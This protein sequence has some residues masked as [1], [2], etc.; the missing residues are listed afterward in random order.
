MKIQ[1][2][3]GL[4]IAFMFVSCSNGEENAIV[5]P[6]TYG[7]VNV[8]VS[9]TLPQPES[10]NAATRSYT[11]TD[12]SNVDV[13]VF[14]GN[15][16][17]MER[18]KVESSQ[19]VT[20]G[21]GVA[22][23]VRLDATSEKRIIH[24][25][26]NGRTA[27]G[28]TDRLNFDD[29]NTNM[30]E[31]TAISSL[32]T[33]SLENVDNGESTLLDNV[34]PLVMWGRFVLDDGINVVSTVNEVKLLR[35]TACIQV[36]KGTVGD[37][38]LN[39]FV[40]EGVTVHKGA[41]CG[42]LAPADC[43]GIVTTPA[44]ANP[45]TGSNYLD[46]R[47]GWVYATEPSL[48]IYER[49]C[50]TDSYMGVIL[51]GSYKGKSGYYKIVMTD[52]NGTPLNII[53]NHRYIV[54]IIGVNG[55]GYE[56]VATATTSAPSNML[57][58]ELQDEDTEFS[59]TVAD[60]QSRMSSSNNMLNLYG[61]TGGTSSAIGVEICTVYSSRG[62]SP[63]VTLPE[64]CTW[65]GNV[66]AQLVESNKYRITGDFTSSANDPVSTILT[67][68]CDN[69]SLPVQISWNPIISDRKDNDSYVFD[70]VNPIDKNWH[71]RIINPS[72]TNWLLLHPSAGSPGDCPGNGMVSEV[73]SKYNSHAYLHV[74]TGT[75]KR[76]TV[77]KTS[78][79][80]EK[81]VA[82]KIIV[83]Q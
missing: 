79:S 3:I 33:I 71:V 23:T 41:G 26:A 4:L 66:N 11:D 55:P 60:G 8:T 59:C 46:Y 67:M 44:T 49:N 47:K 16:Q 17:F 77:L 22:F 82:D 48:Y 40:I 24:L 75:N 56:S 20:T 7:K 43:T 80:G 15:A 13:L 27:D 35:A 29:L 5:S 38:G 74:L 36:K 42:F 76:G 62:I 70:L 45:I 50:T 72:S 69:L 78:I 18:V 81:T 57:K 30:S 39:D 14:D 12:I 2:I 73:S 32:R 61:K 51:K 1:Y 10:V 34:M 52:G 65:L 28:M 37:S 54:T 6:K 31:N 21:T 83:I 25:V 19:M 63:V 58:V 53:R 68:A 9:V 64:N